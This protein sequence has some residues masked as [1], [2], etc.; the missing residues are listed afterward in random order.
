[1][2]WALLKEL[3]LTEAEFSLITSAEHV[4]ETCKALMVWSSKTSNSWVQIQHKAWV[5]VLFVCPVTLDA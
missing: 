1:M 2:L 3:T 5:F 4:V